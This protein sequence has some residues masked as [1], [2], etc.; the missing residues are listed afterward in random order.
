[1]LIMFSKLRQSASASQAS[2]RWLCVSGYRPAKL[3]SD[4]CLGRDAE[5]TRTPDLGMP[6]VLN[7][8]RKQ[9]QVLQTTIGLASITKPCQSDI[10]VLRR[11]IWS[12]RARQSSEQ[13]HTTTVSSKY[14]C[15]EEAHSNAVLMTLASSSTLLCLPMFNAQLM[16]SMFLTH[17]QLLGLKNDSE[18]E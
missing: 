9:I 15:F 5:D 11:Y 13:D 4:W 14:T 16:G 12:M 8:G 3:C 18:Q 17:R 10:W 1:M 2:T 6:R 7:W